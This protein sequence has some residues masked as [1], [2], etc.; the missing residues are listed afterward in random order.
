MQEKN[1]TGSIHISDEVIAICAANGALNTDGVVGLWGGITENIKENIL[2]NLGKPSNFKGIRLTQENE[3][4]YINLYIIVEYGCKIPDVAWEVQ[5][6]VKN[7]VE[8]MTELTVK[9]VI[10]N[11]QGVQTVEEGKA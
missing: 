6:N 1:D 5:E 8:S 7:E 10:I 3:D 9:Q 4:I 2:G 11:I